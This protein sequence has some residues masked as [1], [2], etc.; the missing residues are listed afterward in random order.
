MPTTNRLPLRIRADVGGIGAVLCIG[1]L[2][3]VLAPPLIAAALGVELI[4]FAF[5]LWARVDAQAVEQV[6]RWTWLRRPAMAVWIAVAIHAVLPRLVHTSL[7][8]GTFRQAPLP[9]I[10]A[11]AVLWAGL[12]LVAA[13]PT[14]RPYSDF[15][16]PYLQ[17]RPWLPVVLPTAGFTLLWR[18]AEHWTLVADV[19]H[20]AAAL[21]IV[22]AFLSSMRAFA[23][24]GWT[25]SLRWLS[26]TQTAFA[27]LLLAASTWSTQAV[28]LLWLGAFGGPAFVLAGELAGSTPR[29][30]PLNTRLWR[31]AGWAS[32]AALGW[33]ALVTILQSK[34]PLRV[35][36]LPMAAIAVAISTWIMVGRIELAPERRRLM[37]PGSGVLAGRAAALMVLAFGPIGLVLLWWSGFE[38]HWLTSL[39]A[40]WPA[41]F[42]GLLAAARSERR[43]PQLAPIVRRM[44]AAAPGFAG[45]AYLMI[46]R[47]ERRV[48]GAITGFARVL[49]SPLRDMHTG[50]AQEY[51]LFLIGVGVLALVL[52]LLQ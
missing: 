21:L 41:V 3:L 9:W 39:I 33:P 27:I 29:R 18:Q 24:R 7:G 11:V 36:A 50:D 1:G 40:L 16:G 37:R 22:T 10:E 13:L 4:A 35:V 6:P 32:T 51:L 28:F 26:V 38:P 52:P 2:A 15:P 31:A 49:I 14:A 12:E 46:V 42:G 44:T 17:T 8:H 19:R 5:W 43:L 30:G 47:I 23:R 48:V 25:A 20:V 34:S 45:Y